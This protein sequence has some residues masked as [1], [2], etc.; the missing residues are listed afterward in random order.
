[1]VEVRQ[2]ETFADWLLAL[3]D[4]TAKAKIAAR[5]D[6]LSFGNAGDVEP[7]GEGLSEMRIHHWPGIP[8]VF[9]P[10]R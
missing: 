9:R 10:Y 7:I 8:G 2:A 1:V 4:T 3:R 5:I 6:R